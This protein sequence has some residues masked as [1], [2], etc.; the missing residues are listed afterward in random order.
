[1]EKGCRGDGVI[2]VT[3]DMAEDLCGIPG[4]IRRGDGYRIAGWEER[5]LELTKKMIVTGARRNERG[6]KDW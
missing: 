5:I 6:G 2:S 1:M 3:K 4:C